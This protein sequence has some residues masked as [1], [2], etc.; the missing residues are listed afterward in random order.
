M[1]RASGLT[2]TTL[3]I[4]QVKRAM[5]KAA[6][7]VYLLLD[8]SK[9]DQTGFIKVAQLDEIDVVITD[10]EFPV[11]ARSALERLGLKVILV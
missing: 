2:D 7:Q 10:S 9:W 8:S 11:A 1:D 3:E 6:K 4:A 5:I